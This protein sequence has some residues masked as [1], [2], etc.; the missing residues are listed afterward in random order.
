MIEA[1][2]A[3]T[4]S[5]K[6]IHSLFS[7]SNIR[8]P[9]LKTRT[10]RAKAATTRHKPF[11]DF[12]DII[13]CQTNFLINHHSFRHS[14]YHDYHRNA[15]AHFRPLLYSYSASAIGRRTCKIIL[16]RSWHAPGFARAKLWPGH[17]TQAGDGMGKQQRPIGTAFSLLECIIHNRR[18][19][20][21]VMKQLGSNGIT[22]ASRALHILGQFSF[23]S[24]ELPNNNNVPLPAPHLTFR[25]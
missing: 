2:C 7:V 19:T 21:W 18:T 24:L 9:L 14:R 1:E 8:I 23:T 13:L 25:K 22:R 17:R 20:I 11:H 3:W 10:S 15:A 16:P 4:G 5:N 12:L 6:S